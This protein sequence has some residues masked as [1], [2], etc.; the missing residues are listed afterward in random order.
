M[1]D[2]TVLDV[3]NNKDGSYSVIFEMDDDFTKE[4][5]DILEADHLTE[6]GLITFFEECVRS[7]VE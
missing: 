2:F 7:Y 5:L 1:S 4:V 3:N 6:D